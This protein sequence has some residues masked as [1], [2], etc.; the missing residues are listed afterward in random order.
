MAKKPERTAGACL[1]VISPVSP[2]LW[3]AY[4][5]ANCPGK[6]VGLALIGLQRLCA[7]LHIHIPT[8]APASSPEPLFL[9]E[10][11]LLHQVLRPGCL[12]PD[13]WQSWVA[14]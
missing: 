3:A 12:P 4:C 10:S 5:F 7:V 8:V 9:V 6:A 13:R 2:P 14:C 11:L 1:I